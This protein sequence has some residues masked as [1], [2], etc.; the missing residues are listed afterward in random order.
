MA[1]GLQ[2]STSV[3]ISIE[4]SPGGTPR[5]ITGFVM[6]L[7]GAKIAVET[8]SSEGFGD[9]WRKHAPTGMRN[10]PDIPIG[11]LFNTTATTGPH[12]TLRPGDS[13]AE[14]NSVGRE[15]VIV[16]GDSKTLTVTGHLVEYEAKPENGKLT[17]FNSLFRPT[18]AAVW[19]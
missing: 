9:A 17:R 13:D 7:G 10:C 6:E 4:D 16:F 12:V 1:T 8:E 5:T 15:L 3:T 11:G 19:S 2:G 14:P 18:G